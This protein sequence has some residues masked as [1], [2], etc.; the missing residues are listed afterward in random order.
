MSWSKTNWYQLVQSCLRQVICKTRALVTGRDVEV[1]CR[2]QQLETGLKAGI[3]CAA[4][5]GMTAL[6]N[7]VMMVGYAFKN[8]SYAT[9]SQLDAKKSICSVGMLMTR[10]VHTL[11]TFYGLCL[12]AVP[13]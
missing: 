3:K 11:I 4:V 5:H 13:H 2:V 7:F 10:P 9:D 8:C 12:E 6:M 1:V